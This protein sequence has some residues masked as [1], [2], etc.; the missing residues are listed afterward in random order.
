MYFLSVVFPR[1]PFGTAGKISFPSTVHRY[2]LFFRRKFSDNGKTNDPPCPN[3]KY[4]IWN[5]FVF[6]LF[7]RSSAFRGGNDS[8]ARR[9]R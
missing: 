2:D 6:A 7:L 1:M 9:K 5:T 8:F 4:D 3:Q